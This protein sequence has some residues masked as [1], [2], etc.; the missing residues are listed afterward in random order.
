MRVLHPACVRAFAAALLCLALDLLTAGAAAA[1]DWLPLSQEDLKMTSE[2][3]APG[4]PAVY[5][6]RQVDRSDSAYHETVYER[7]KILTDEGRKYAD[8][9][10]P[11][12]KGTEY[13]TG[14][15]ARTILP[16][17]TVIPF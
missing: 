17:G 9:E 10:I 15:T 16:D 8:I 6:Y 12:E 4:A 7:L 3:K 14:I 2:P 13:V 11:Y 5:L 1:E